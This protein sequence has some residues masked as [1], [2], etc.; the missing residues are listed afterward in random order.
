MSGMIES[1]YMTVRGRPV[2]LVFEEGE[3]EGVAAIDNDLDMF[4]FLPTPDDTTPQWILSRSSELFWPL[5]S[6]LLPQSP[7]FLHNQIDA[8]EAQRYLKLR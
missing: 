6:L 3:E 5:D 8:N 4:Q 1:C 7:L 2:D